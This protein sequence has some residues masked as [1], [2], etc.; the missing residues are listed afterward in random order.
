MNMPH[1]SSSTG[2]RHLVSLVLAAT[3]ALVAFV[4][5][6]S[7]WIGVCPEGRIPHEARIAAASRPVAVH[8]V[9]MRNL[10]WNAGSNHVAGGSLGL[11]HN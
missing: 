1:R 9:A 4:A 3:V 7:F 10:P 11:G 6:V 5:T 2:T 8:P